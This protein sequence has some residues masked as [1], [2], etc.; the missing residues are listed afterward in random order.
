MANF[1]ITA[2]IYKQAE[3]GYV[4]IMQHNN[5]KGYV[6]YDT[7]KAKYADQLKGVSD[8]LGERKSAG[9]EVKLELKAEPTTY[10]AESGKEYLDPDSITIVKVG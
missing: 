2:K 8:L 9:V 6:H 5:V 4:V 7:L 1:K 3:G 10:V